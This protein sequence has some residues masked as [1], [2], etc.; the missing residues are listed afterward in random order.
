MNGN[1]QKYAFGKIKGISKRK[2]LLYI[3]EKSSIRNRNIN[4]N[5]RKAFNGKFDEKF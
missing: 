4:G 2:E 5:K 1:N 3:E